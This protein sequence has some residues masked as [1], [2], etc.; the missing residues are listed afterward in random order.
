MRSKFCLTAAD[1][2]ALAAICHE[3]I[4]T[5]GWP[6]TFAIVDEGGHLLHFERRD[7]A[8]VSTI[9]VAIGKARTAAFSRSPTRLMEARL[10]D[11]PALFFL[12]AMPMQGGLP[13]LHEGQCVGGIGVSGGTPQQDE[14]VAGAALG[15]LGVPGAE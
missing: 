5:G 4:E 10:K 11:N 14:E 12:N 3:A 2:R 6:M 9:D 7:A 8:R 15:A 1:V 13:I